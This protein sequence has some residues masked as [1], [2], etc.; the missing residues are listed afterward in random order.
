VLTRGGVLTV[1]QDV[2]MYIGTLGGG[3]TIEQGLA[4]NRK[5]YLHV[6]GGKVSL[7]GIALEEGSGAK[8]VEER[9][10]RLSAQD[11]GKVLLL[12]LP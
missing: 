9:Q 6:A 12:D 10:L 1:H 11:A 2:N 7:N 5:A 8:I 3:R 4:Q